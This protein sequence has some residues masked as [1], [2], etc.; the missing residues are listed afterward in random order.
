M[1]EPPDR[2]GDDD[3]RTLVPVRE[4][5]DG[6]FRNGI[7]VPRGTEPDPQPQ[8]WRE[9]LEST[10]KIR[11]EDRRLWV[12][13]AAVL[14]VLVVVMVLSSSG[15]PQEAPKAQRDF[16]AA[17]R[18]G[19]TQVRNGNDITLVTAARERA[20]RACEHLPRGGKVENWIGTLTKVGTVFG[21]NQGEVAVSLGDGVKLRTWNHKSED[22]KD[23]TLVDSHSDVYQELAKRKTGDRV[24]FSGTFVPKGP[25]CLHETSLFARNGMLTP[26]FVFRFT[27]VAALQP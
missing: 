22:T 25:V 17:V 9:R 16:L 19:Q 23:H 27:S 13:A 8:G 6:Y 2:D 24:V 3:D 21:G 12:G 11:L 1:T 5:A 20:S 10:Y 18:H 7:W 15:S 26:G 4:R 14:L